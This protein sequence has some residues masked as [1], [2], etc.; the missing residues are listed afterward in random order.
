MAIFVFKI[1]FGVLFSKN[2]MKKTKCFP[3]SIRTVPVFS[4][5]F[6][7]Q[8]TYKNL[9]EPDQSV[10]KKASGCGIKLKSSFGLTIFIPLSESTDKYFYYKS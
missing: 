2:K 5:I 3:R 10:R 6:C 4:A 8:A 1:L 7:N 9:I